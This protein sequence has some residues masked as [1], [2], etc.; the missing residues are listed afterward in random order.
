M[1]EFVA[2]Q[3]TDDADPDRWIAFDIHEDTV[4]VSWDYTET[5]LNADEL[6]A[7]IDLLRHGQREF[8]AVDND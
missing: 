3:Y 2:T 7:L 6:A 8:F 4:T 1:G 5:T